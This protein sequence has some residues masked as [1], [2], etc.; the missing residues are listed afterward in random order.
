[1]S[2]QITQGN[3]GGLVI[4]RAS[5]EVMGIDSVGT[6]HGTIGCSIPIDDVIEQAEE[7]SI[8]VDSSE[9]KC[10]RTTEVLNHYEPEQLKE[11]AEYLIDYF[12]D[13]IKIRDY[14]NAYT[15]FGSDIQSELSYVDFR[16][17]YSHVVELDYKDVEHEVINNYQ[18]KS[19]V[20]VTIE[21]KP[22]NKEKTK[23][24]N[25]DYT[26]K[27]GLENDQFRILEIETP[28]K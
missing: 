19:I 8:E 10:A 9:V 6:Q 17:D 20:R 22:T 18:V 3:S 27:I 24:Q 14:V 23:T 26:F 5:G 21:S 25:I 28:E 2:A 12:F 4:S 1:I 15:L 16:E 7:W 11:N 13:G